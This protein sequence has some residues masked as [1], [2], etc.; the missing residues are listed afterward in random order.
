MRKVMWIVPAI[1]LFAALG[2]PSTASANEYAYNF[3]LQDGAITVTGTAV[4][5]N[6]LGAVDFETCDCI[7]DIKISDPSAGFT[8]SLVTLNSQGVQT[9]G[10]LQIGPSAWNVT[11]SLITFDFDAAASTT[12]FLSL[13]P[14][15]DTSL[16]FISDGEIEATNS[17]GQTVSASASGVMDVAT[18]E[19]SSLSLMIA[20]L[21]GLTLLVGVKR[22]RGSRLT[23]EV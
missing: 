17:I 13:I 21:M 9:A 16:S 14:G 23:T 18:P 4:L 8:A 6:A 7:G 1:A 12:E 5:T 3:D 19:P 2:L 10:A 11:P 22:Y 20:G 15:D